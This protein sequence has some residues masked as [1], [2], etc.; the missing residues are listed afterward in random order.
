MKYVIRAVIDNEGKLLK[1]ASKCGE[2]LIAIDGDIVYYWT[3]EQ[4][5]QRYKQ[6]CA[7][8]DKKEKIEFRKYILL[9]IIVSIIF[10]IVLAAII[11]L[12]RHLGVLP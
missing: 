3:D 12:L 1:F 7:K 8:Q 4:G 10:S 2:K 11:W 6:E 9:R 5:L